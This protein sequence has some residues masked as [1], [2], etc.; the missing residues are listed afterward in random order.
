MK[1]SVT[2]L[3]STFRRFDTDTSG[4]TRH[5]PLIIQKVQLQYAWYIDFNMHIALGAISYQEKRN[6]VGN[7][8]GIQVD[9]FPSYLY[10]T[11]STVH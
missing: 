6:F 9:L 8:S 7:I 1:T 10:T 4:T 2:I 11:H 5:K 3:N